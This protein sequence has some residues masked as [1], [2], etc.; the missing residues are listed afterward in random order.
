MGGTV[1]AMAPN[2]SRGIVVVGGG[3]YSLMI[4]RSTA[5]SM[6]N[7]LWETAQAD[8]QDREFLFAI[9]QS[10]FDRADPVIH[11]ELI[12]QPLGGGEPKRLML[13]ESM[14]DCQV[15]NIA[16]EVMARSMNMSMLAPAVDKVWGIEDVTGEVT[17]GSVL[18]QI[19]TQLGPRPLDVN[20]PPDDDNGAHGAVIDDP[21]AVLMV[22]RFLFKGIFENLCEGPCNPG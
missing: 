12:E 9:F 22:E 2:L 5:F 4:W 7:S 1:V 19:D 10:T 20:M 8:I 13:V 18:L 11:K 16:T 15:P 3:N 17:E 6:L 21:A 14:G